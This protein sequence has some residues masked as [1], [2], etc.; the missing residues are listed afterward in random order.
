MQDL[1][2]G[3]KCTNIISNKTRIGLYFLE[4]TD[5]FLRPAFILL[6]F[7]RQLKDRLVQ[8]ALG[9]T[10]CMTTVLRKEDGELPGSN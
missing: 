8:R 7:Y 1:Y 2:I 3:C 4:E 10:G 9:D 6:S 5:Y